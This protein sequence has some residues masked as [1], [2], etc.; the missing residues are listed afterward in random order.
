MNTND[1]PAFPVPTDHGFVNEG[2]TGMT[3]RDYFAAAAPPIPDDVLEDRMIALLRDV[4]TMPLWN[5]GVLQ[6]LAEL[7]ARWRGLCA[8]AMLAERAK[9]KR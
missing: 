4:G 9:E 6:Q 8:D 2:A 7:N 1:I 3:L 5:T